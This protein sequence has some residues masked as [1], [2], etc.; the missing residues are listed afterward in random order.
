MLVKYQIG[1][2]T[3][4]IPNLLSPIPAF[5][6]LKTPVQISNSRQNQ[7]LR[8]DLLNFLAILCISN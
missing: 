6:W 5:C 1:N 7:L 4:I 8:N 2:I 3:E